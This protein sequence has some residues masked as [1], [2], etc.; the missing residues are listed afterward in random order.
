MVFGL[1]GYQFGMHKPAFLRDRVQEAGGAMVAAHPYRRR[2]PRNQHPS[3]QQVE[4]A[5]ERASGEELFSACSAIETVNG[6]GKPE[7]N[8]FSKMLSN[9]L[10]LPG[11]GG[12]DIHRAEHIGRACTKFHHRI[13]SLHDLVMALNQGACEAELG[14]AA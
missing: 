1:H 4:D 8:S 2:Y 3:P 5:L 12:S 10:R 13:S 6:R 9:Y 14:Y 11:T 7:E